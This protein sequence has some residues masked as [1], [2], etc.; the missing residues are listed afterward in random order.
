[1]FFIVP[2]HLLL[3][4]NIYGV[5]RGKEEEA[6]ERIREQIYNERL[7]NFSYICPLFFIYSL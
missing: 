4:L 7:V 6:E 1:M 3:A 5:S 2:E